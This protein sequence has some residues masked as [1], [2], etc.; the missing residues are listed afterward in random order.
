MP[1]PP[2]R[3]M[4]MRHFSSIPRHSNDQRNSAA[5][6]QHSLLDLKH[7]LHVTQNARTLFCCS[8][9]RWKQN[10]STK[11]RAL[12]L[13]F[14]WPWCY[15]IAPSW[16]WR[17][18][19]E[20]GGSYDRAEIFEIDRAAQ[21]RYILFLI[22][23]LPYYFSC[24]SNS[25]STVTDGDPAIPLPTTQPCGK[26][27]FA[28]VT[29]VKQSLHTADKPRPTT[30]KPCPTASDPVNDGSTNANSVAVVFE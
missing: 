8:K 19:T 6:I 28:A 14:D 17:L 1:A 13:Y 4:R 7:Q 9:R 30:S 20:V 15:S 11:I 22:Y 18:E 26:Y 12:N 21:P 10:C 25:P 27:V 16:K 5:D 29:T 3:Q 2:P 23:I 24:A